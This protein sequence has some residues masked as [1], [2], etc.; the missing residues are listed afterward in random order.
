MRLETTDLD[1]LSNSGSEEEGEEFPDT[2]IRPQFN[3]EPFNEGDKLFVNLS[4]LT[5]AICDENLDSLQTH[6]SAFSN[7]VYLRQGFKPY[8]PLKGDTRVENDRDIP[9]VPKASFVGLF[10]IGLR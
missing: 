6:F 10:A 8:L 4:E 1:E 7:G 3:T 5:E 9:I 2:I